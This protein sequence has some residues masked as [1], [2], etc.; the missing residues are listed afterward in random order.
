MPLK[1]IFYA[2]LPFFNPPVDMVYF[3]ASLNIS[4]LSVVNW[5]SNF[6][7]PGYLSCL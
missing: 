4:E 5:N 7:F 6:S 2:L 3:I 1:N